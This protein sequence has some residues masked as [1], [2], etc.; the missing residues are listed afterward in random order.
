MLRNSK[1][2]H[3]ITIR[4]TDWEIGTV[5]KFYFDDETWASA[6]SWS[7]WVAALAAGWYWSRPFPL[8]ASPTGNRG[9]WASR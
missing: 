9:A 5:D 4:A 1:G 6:T 8:V 7:K 3:G 2:L